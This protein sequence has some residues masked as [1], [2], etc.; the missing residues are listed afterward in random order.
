MTKR[1]SKLFV[2]LAFCVH[3]GV[4][5][6]WSETGKLLV[7][8]QDLQKRPVKGV[9]IGIEGARWFRHHGQRWQGAASTNERYQRK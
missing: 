4:T 3:G 7:L 9:E 8:V 2:L 5:P 6:L 1:I